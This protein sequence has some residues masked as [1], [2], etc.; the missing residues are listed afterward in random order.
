MND[1]MR[2]KGK[3][4][5][6]K[7]TNEEMADS[8]IER[9]EEERRWHRGLR[10]N[11]CQ[12]TMNAGLDLPMDYVIRDNIRRN[13]ER[14][15][16]VI[17]VDGNMTNEARAFYSQFPNVTAIDSPWKDDYRAQYQKAADAVSEG[18]WILWLDADEQPSKPLLDFISKRDFEGNMMKLPCVLHLQAED[19]LFYP[20]EPK[21]NEKYVGQWSKPILFRKEKTLNFIAAGSHVFPSHG[22][23]ERSQYIPFEYIHF[24]TLESFVEN[25]VL[26]AFLNP[27]F[28]QFSPE[29]AARFKMLTS[30]FKSTKDFKKSMKDGTWS[31]PLQRFAWMRRREA[32]NPVSR[33]AWQYFIVEG[34]P[35]PEQDDFMQWDNVKQYVQSE[36]CMSILRQSVLNGCAFPQIER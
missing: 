17:I 6:K 3:A 18:E 36:E 34:H 31:L 25:D 19:G 22:Y 23:N 30:G 35:M 15:D 29:N 28:Q 20:S 4:E 24:K 32:L 9:R 27:E 1:M 33:L 10:V 2:E 8:F 16:R 13:H 5:M 14:F 7:K 21:P 11:L 26:Q 12:M